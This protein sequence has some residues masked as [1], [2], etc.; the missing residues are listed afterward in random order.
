MNI[1]LQPFPRN[2]L[3][4]WMNGYLF[5]LFKKKAW[6]WLCVNFSL[7]K[8]SFTFYVLYAFSNLNVDNRSW[9]LNS[10]HLLNPPI[11]MNYLLLFFKKLSASLLKLWYFYFYYELV[12]CTSCT[13]NHCDCL[14][15]EIAWKLYTEAVVYIVLNK[16]CL[17]IKTK[18]IIKWTKLV[19]WML[20][21]FHAQAYT[22]SKSS[23]ATCIS[24]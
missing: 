10:L 22:S 24:Y 4:T 15:V 12:L 8:S 2:I 6:R 16:S 7:K 14:K 19:Q 23:D 21:A 11:K 13:V 3:I 20:K 18:Y 9:F 17:Y 1:V 5:K